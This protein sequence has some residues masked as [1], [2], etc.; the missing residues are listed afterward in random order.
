MLVTKV[1]YWFGS[2]LDHCAQKKL[3]Y[4]LIYK[5]ME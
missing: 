3:N 5:P 4:M 2:D 1:A